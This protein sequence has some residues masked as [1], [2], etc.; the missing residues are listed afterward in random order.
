MTC[1]TPMALRPPRRKRRDCR[2]SSASDG[3]ALACL[4][5]WCSRMRFPFSIAVA[6]A[7]A[8][9]RGTT[10]LLAGVVLIGCGNATP[11]TA[12]GVSSTSG[13]EQSAVTPRPPD[14]AW[15]MRATFWDAVR[16]RDALI[17]GDL[18]VAQ[19]A[20]ERIAATDYTRVVPGDWKVGVGALQQHAAALSI[21]P[22]LSTAAQEFGRMALTCGECHALRARGPGRTLTVPLPWEDPPETLD[23]RMERHQMGIDQLWDGLV[24]PSDNAWRTGTITITRAP[25]RAPEQS[26]E[27]VSPDLH[28]RIEA[29]RELGQPARLATT[30][31]ERARVFGELIAGCAQ[32][33]YLQR[34]ARGEAQSPSQEHSR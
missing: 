11:S 18:A 28:A 25:L 22:D 33:H 12:R 17:D 10:L 16:A 21:A 13:A 24:L 4:L 29:T 19:G 15:H 23:Q 1:S 7:N 2:Q 32:C 31:L 27:A 3:S 5:H 8:A 34:P 30:Y 6:S 26:E 9:V 20:A 14:L